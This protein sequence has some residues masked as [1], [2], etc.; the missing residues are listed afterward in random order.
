MHNSLRGEAMVTVEQARR[1]KVQVGHM[2]R[3]IPEVN[4]IGITRLGNG[5][6]VRVNLVSK[7]SDTSKLP[8]AVDGVPIQTKIVGRAKIHSA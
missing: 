7:P 4:G 8:V 3:H 1:A 6:A 2:V 5:W